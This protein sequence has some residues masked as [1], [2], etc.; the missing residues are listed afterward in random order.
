MDFQLSLQS[1]SAN[2][3]YPE[4]PLAVDPE[5][6]ISDVIRLLQAQKAGAVVVCEEEAMTGIL[7]ERDVLKLMASGDDLERPVS[8]VM[9]NNPAK[10][11]AQATV[12]QVID[13]MSQGGYRH[14]PLMDPSD[15]SKP[16][17]MIDVKGIV[18]YLVEHFPSTIYNLPPTPNQSLNEREGA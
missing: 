4:P 14:L 17:G 9:S 10:I 15:S 6:S 12:G 7:T 3:A 13:L 18:R 2:S 5:T 1:E 11:D 8:T 16:I